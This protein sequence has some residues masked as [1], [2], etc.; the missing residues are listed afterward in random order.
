[1]PNLQEILVADGTGPA[2]NFYYCKMMVNLY[3]VISCYISTL[4]IVLTTGMFKPSS[5]PFDIS[6]R[7]FLS[8]RV[9]PIPLPVLGDLPRDGDSDPDLVEG[10]QGLFNA[11]LAPLD[12]DKYLA[13]VSLIGAG[14]DFDDRLPAGLAVGLVIGFGVDFALDSC[15]LLVLPVLFLVCLVPHPTIFSGLIHSSYLHWK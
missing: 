2:L 3:P 4:F 10:E 9:R 8:D 11:P 14:A 6:D 7:E 15:P 5:S 13:G 12:A 1:M